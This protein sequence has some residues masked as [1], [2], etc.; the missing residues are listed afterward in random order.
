MEL[1]GSI[2]ANFILYTLLLLSLNNFIVGKTSLLPVGHLAFFG[3]GAITIGI[4]VSDCG[5]SPWLAL[6]IAL[7]VGILVSLV[8]GLTTLR[9]DSDYFILLSIALC[10]IVRS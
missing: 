7:L 10:E 4:L 9:L 3:I 6:V 8:V 2:T 5:L 1:L